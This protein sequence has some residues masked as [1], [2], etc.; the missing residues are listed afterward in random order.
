MNENIGVKGGKQDRKRR[1][2]ITKNQKKKLKQYYQ[3]EKEKQLKQLEKEVKKLQVVSFFQ[4]VPLVITGKTWEALVSPKTFSE[5]KEEETESSLLITESFSDN[6]ETTVLNQLRFISGKKEIS[7]RIA[8]ETKNVSKK[9]SISI[10][11]K[12]IE[13]IEIQKEGEDSS[14][15]IVES[16]LSELSHASEELLQ[17]EAVTQE[18]EFGT[19]DQIEKSSEVEVKEQEQNFI[20]M[21]VAVEIDTKTSQRKIAGIGNQVEWSEQK[22]EKLKSQKIVNEYNQK[23]KDVRIDLKNLIY[24]YNV[25][26][27]S[28]DKIYE[29]EEAERMIEKLNTI[30]KKMEELEEKIQIP[31]IAKVEDNYLYTL[32]EEYIEEFKNKRF[33]EEVKDSDL[34][35]LISEKLDE[36]DREKEKLSKKLEQ[37]KENLEMD[38][39]KLDKLKDQY[40]KFDSFNTK[41]LKF[42]GE[43]DFILKDLEEKV[44]HA[45]KE[46]EKVEIKVRGLEHQ[47]RSLL[48]LLALQKMIPG[49]KSAKKVALATAAYLMFMRNLLRPRLETKRYRIIEVTDYS[50]DIEHSMEQLQKTGTLVKKSS[51]ELERLI[52]IFQKDYAEYL[53]VLPECD[54]LLANLEEVRD[55]L[56]E[57][58]FELKRITKDHQKNLEKNKEKIKEMKIEALNN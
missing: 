26:V 52:R 28:S 38:E 49:P 45:T 32:I 18:I 3:G 31:D 35:I 58:E 25:L 15:F 17:E 40:E 50:K 57:K 1:M 19:I 21:P 6:E 20:P 37:K 5:K 27:D 43:Q 12:E 29:S 4:A 47:S 36:L 22:L 55:S 46:S 7:Q 39:E 51:S 54:K 53:G 56:K 13:D 9:S 10:E 2:I 16:T 34:Y 42:Q 33:V 23:L 14:N 30:I 24:E 41:L 11:E 44:A 8:Q 48:A